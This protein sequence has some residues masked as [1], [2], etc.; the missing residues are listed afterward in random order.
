M[1]IEILVIL[2]FLFGIAVVGAILVMVPCKIME[3]LIG[4][5][6]KKETEENDNNN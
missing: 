2:G 4:M 6:K 3:Y 5:F 1:L